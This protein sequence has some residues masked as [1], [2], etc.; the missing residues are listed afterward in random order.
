MNK[1]IV[2]VFYIGF[3]P[4]APGTFGSFFGVIIGFLAQQIGSFPFF[5][6]VT[7]VLFFVG[8][9][10]SSSYISQTENIDDPQEI[11]IDEVVGQ[12][13][14]YFPVSFY[15][16]WL[17]TESLNLNFSFW[18]TAFVIF[19]IFDILKPWPINWADRLNS[20]LGVML[21]DLLAG[22][23]TALAMFGLLLVI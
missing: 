10:A 4:F 15:S 22:I 12:L 1:F 16:W 5:I 18:L 23:Y 19:R 13:V 21:D 17:S 20:S 6:F 2:S 8:W 11:V 7:V 14:S 9:K 3:L